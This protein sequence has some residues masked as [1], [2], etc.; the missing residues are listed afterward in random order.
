MVTVRRRDVRYVMAGIDEILRGS[1]VQ[2]ALRAEAE[3]S[4]AEAKSI[5]SRHVDTGAYLASL[6]IDARRGRTRAVYRVVAEDRKATL[7][8]AR[9]G[10]LK[11]GMRANSRER[12]R[13]RA[14][15]RRYER[16]IAR[17]EAREGF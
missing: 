10:I 14:A 13:V 12:S 11:K 17:E 8:E 2:R 15:E 7:L 9:F 4:L 5:A 3:K 16:A 6:R 1:G